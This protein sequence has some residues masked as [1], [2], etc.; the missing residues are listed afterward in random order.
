MPDFSS[1]LPI[2]SLIL[3]LGAAV[4]VVFAFIGNK[5]RG[6][7]EAQGNTIAALNSTIAALQAQDE[8]REKQ[9]QV[10]EKKVARCEGVISTISYTLKDRRRLRLEVKD[11]FV[12]L[13]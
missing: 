8:I 7:S 4:G 2:M 5:N 9:I 6:L 10:I 12:T 11:D 1:L 3:A 13:I